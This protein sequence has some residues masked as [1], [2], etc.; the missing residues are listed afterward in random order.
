MFSGGVGEYV[1]RREVRDFGDLGK[2]FG[3]AIREE[4]NARVVTTELLPAGEC[5]RAT[6]AWCLR[7]QCTTEWKHN[8]HF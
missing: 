8:I 4:L 2:L 7:V 3:Q 1:Y 6:C 5:I